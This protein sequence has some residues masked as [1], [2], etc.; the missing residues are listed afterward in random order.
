MKKVLSIILC[1][2]LLCGC[3]SQSVFA[4]ADFRIVK[5]DTVEKYSTSDNLAVF[6][7][8]SF[9]GFGSGT[10][11][12]VITDTFS[13]SG[14]KSVMQSGR[15]STGG[16][17]K[18]HNLFGRKLT[19]K[20]VGRT[21]ELS[22][23]VY[24]DKN[25]GVYKQSAEKLTDED[26]EACKYSDD[27]L[28]ES[29]ST[30]F[31]VYLTGP[32]D[33]NYKYR[34]GT[35]SRQNYDINWNE[36]SLIKYEY[37][38]QEKYL[39]TGSTEEK[40]DPYLD[41]VR[42]AQGGDY[43][44][45]QAVCDTF[46]IDDITVKELGAFSYQAAKADDIEAYELTEKLEANTD[47]PFCNF[48]ANS[49]R[50][51]IT[52]E[53]S[54][55]G[56]KSIIQS[57]RTSPSAT[58][59]IHNLF[60]N[61]L[62]MEDVGR[63]FLIKMYVYADKESGVYKQA[64]TGI[65]A[66]EIE[67]YKYTDEELKESTG[68][69]FQLYLAGPDGKNYKYRTGSNGI[70][71]VKK[72]PVR[73][74]EWTP[75]TYYYTVKESYISTGS[76]E[77]LSDPYLDSIRVAQAGSTT[78]INKAFSDTIYIDD[79]TVNEVGAEIQSCFYD[80][81]MYMTGRFTDT[82]P[83]IDAK[84]MMM[85][86]D[87]T[88]KLIGTKIQSA[89]VPSD[90]T[91]K[92]SMVYNVKSDESK[93]YGTVW[94]GINPITPMTEFSKIYNPENFVPPEIGVERAK[95]MLSLSKA[96][97]KDALSFDERADRENEYFQSATD[98]YVSA[99]NP[100][101]KA[102]S[103]EYINVSPDYA[104]VVKFDISDSSMQSFSHAYLS[105]Y[106]QS[107]ATGGKVGLYAIN[108]DWTEENLTYNKISSGM[109]KICELDVGYKDIVY[110]FDISSYANKMVKN[111]Q[112]TL[113]FCLK[114]TDANA[115]FIS[116][117]STQKSYKAAM[118]FEGIGMKEGEKEVSSFDYANYVTAMKKKNRGTKGS[119]VPTPTR[120]LSSL[121]DYTPV[122][123]APVL[124][125]YGSPITEDRYEATGYF[126]MKQID[127]RW[128]FID[129][130]GYKQLHIGVGVV[131]PEKNNEKE[132]N[133]FNAKYGTDENWA[134]MVV[135]EL[136]PYGFNGCGFV[137][138]YK[139]MLDASEATPLNQTGFNGVLSGHDKS[140][141][142]NVMNVF[143]PYFDTK[144][145]ARVKDMIGTYADNPHVIGWS[146]DNEPPANDNMLRACLEADPYNI[147][148]AY[149]YYTAW[150]WLKHRHGEDA[151]IDDIT[152]TDKMDW[153]EF[154]YDR[155]M[156]VVV[157]AIR[158]YDQN[159]LIFGPK[160]DKP[161]RGSFRGVSR[162]VDVV[163][164]D[165]YGNAWTAEHSQMDSFYRWAGKPMINAEWYAKGADACTEETGLTNFSGVGYQATTQ[166]ERGYYYQ[167]FVI[168]MLESRA[169]VGWHWF[170]YIDNPGDDKY[171]EGAD[172]NAN[173][174]I[175]TNFY[176]PWTELLS[177][178]K[179]INENAYSLIDYFDN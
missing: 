49:K 106:T 133:A 4:E 174:G 134:N 52:D 58:V 111:G 63:T 102:I 66:T 96:E 42:V 142:D 116:W 144:A 19:S 69:E 45:N 177:Q 59:K 6:E 100:D 126:Y 167:N 135:D 118:I 105:F 37:T 55:S 41:S 64:V 83:D 171:D 65:P 26:K 85:E 168:N 8:K 68:C 30:L 163:M 130:E 13:R 119:Y 154:V 51:A 172:T 124:N 86:Y 38:V 61:K 101:T 90:R 162:W 127:G 103:D 1:I 79:I 67:Q 149:S 87:S 120:I 3:F 147:D 91:E 21:F 27:E 88:G 81:T 138:N 99:K 110:F 151:T 82:C 40:T 139:L 121:T 170:R 46:Y 157:T 148:Q 57:G 175:Y 20:D 17:V 89:P 136:R 125:K 117:K 164:Y 72:Y 104:G 23:Y 108:S 70:N 71:T 77:D 93:V 97:Y 179:L 160:L 48:G 74:N 75:L 92:S 178:M 122:D 5:N 44:I 165:Y 169:F 114:T 158:K 25:S 18:I 132:I 166:K 36:W 2:I 173:K 24:A 95:E 11:N 54:R 53:F 9:C 80:G 98:V 15:V 137:G 156:N 29:T 47:A 16:T 10:Y 14:D 34:T 78:D 107:V 128:W 56:N 12:T 7:H 22:F 62:T 35:V 141:N 39:S 28:K 146:F 140:Y 31:S 131:R 60:G 129:P 152:D 150:E 143:D 123:K 176:T 155:Y 73:W 43:S 33:K 159:H 84:M 113:S 32:D 76:T 112:K 50:T 145:D 153:V 94:S 115:S 161:H 109:E